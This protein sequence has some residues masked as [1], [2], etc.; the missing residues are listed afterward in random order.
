MPPVFTKSYAKRLNEICAM[1]VREAKDG[2]EIMQGLALVAPG[3]YHMTLQT[4]GN[5]NFVKVYQD[6]K[7]NGHRPAVDVLFESMAKEAGA[8]GIGVLL[9][10]MGKDGAKG[11]KQMRDVGAITIGQDKQSSVVY[12]MPMEAKKLGAVQHELPLSQIPQC[13]L[14]SISRKWKNR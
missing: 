9:T 4:R 8:N 11:L 12:G 5:R 1:Q 13:L 14:K 10:G 2:D 7:V 3:D 6:E